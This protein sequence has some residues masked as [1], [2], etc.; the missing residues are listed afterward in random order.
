MDA[1]IG[2]R[3]EANQRAAKVPADSPLHKQLTDLAS[4]SDQIRSEIVATKEGG[5]ITGEER[6]RE[7]VTG[8]CYGERQRLQ[9]PSDGCPGGTGPPCWA[10]LEEVIQKFQKLTAAQLPELTRSCR[11]KARADSGHVRRRLAEAAPF[12]GGWPKRD[13]PGPCVGEGLTVDGTQ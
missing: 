10:E 2:V 11:A 9:W 7:Y 4:S 1:I 13:C 5:A 6:L 8:K 3:D 12:L